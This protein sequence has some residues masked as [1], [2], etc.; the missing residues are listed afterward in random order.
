MHF[1]SVEQKGKPMKRFVIPTR[2]YSGAD[3]LQKLRDYHDKDVWVVCDSF[4][5]QG[6]AIE[7]LKEQ[8]D[9]DRVSLFSD[10]LPEPPIATIVAGI[11]QMQQ[12]KPQVVIG[13]GGGSAIDAAKAMVYFGRQ[14]GM[15]IETFIA[16]PTT[17]GTGSEVTSAS[18]ISDPELGIKY[19]LF[20]DAIYPDIALLEPQLVMS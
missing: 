11:G 4:L 3:S 1:Q 16:I 5:A 9:A 20:D 8:L 19:P 14:L 17:S 10:V 2:I 18:V 7:R 15:D 6:G 12:V 13:F